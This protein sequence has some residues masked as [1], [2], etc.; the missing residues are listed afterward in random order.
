[1][2]DP[3]R[4]TAIIELQNFIKKNVGKK[5]LMNKLAAQG[6]SKSMVRSHN[7]GGLMDDNFSKIASNV[8]K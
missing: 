3:V 1:M 2:T 5:Q 8:N 4:T 7:K 6:A